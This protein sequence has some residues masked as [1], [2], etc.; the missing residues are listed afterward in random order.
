MKHL[1]FFFF[2][3]FSFTLS[4]QVLDKSE[5]RFFAE[6]L[7]EREVLTA[8]GYE[9]FVDRINQG[10]L[11]IFTPRRS[12]DF[13]PFNQEPLKMSTF[14]NYL[15]HIFTREYDYRTAKTQMQEKSMTLFGSPP[16]TRLSPEQE[17]ELLGW[18]RDEL[19]DED[20]PAIER[21]LGHDVFTAGMLP[22][23]FMQFARSGS[24]SR[25]KPGY[26]EVAEI[27][28]PQ[29][30]PQRSVLGH[31][32]ASLLDILEELG[33]V[34]EEDRAQLR[35]TEKI[36]PD[37]H[38][39]SELAKIVEARESRPQN[40]EKNLAYL[41][42]ATTSGLLSNDDLTLLRNDSAFLHGSRKLPAIRRFQRGVNIL[43]TDIRP[44]TKL[45]KYL[46]LL[47]NTLR[48]IDP[49]FA[50]IRFDSKVTP[51][52]EVPTR[53]YQDGPDLTITMTGGEKAI[54]FTERASRSM[55]DDEGVP[56]F[57][58]SPN[59]VVHLNEYLVAKGSEKEL[60]A[61]K[62]QPGTNSSS[63]PTYQ[64][65]V[66]LLLTEQ[67]AR[68]LIVRTMEEMYLGPGGLRSRR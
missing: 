51:N 56:R 27:S 26:K 8:A 12:M 11:G 46:E 19:A 59:L 31:D 40:I 29:V 57:W 6:E 4:A 67:E 14:V 48:N 33:I 20:G 28:E 55:L 24:I 37:Q 39:L 47:E 58:V 42:Q 13:S 2:L 17:E 9:E 63:P 44:A 66:F 41:D 52:E 34:R 53:P 21:A 68:T 23:Y 15:G 45:D 25:K 16:P 38:V 10:R 43:K 61:L 5:A 3:T 32:V 49:A 50:D 60:Y 54:T 7:H 65:V 1:Y 36:S 62:V 35:R 18:G 22:P 64:E 30:S